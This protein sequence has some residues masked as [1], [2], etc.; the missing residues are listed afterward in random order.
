MFQNK[1]RIEG[2]L[3]RQ[4]FT[5]FMSAC[6][7][8]PVIRLRNT[9][10][11][12]GQTAFHA[13][14]LDVHVAA[15][16]PA[17]IDGARSSRTVGASCCTSAKI[18]A[19]GCLGVHSSSAA[20]LH[21]TRSNISFCFRVMRTWVENTNQLARMGCG[22]VLCAYLCPQGKLV[23]RLLGEKTPPSCTCQSLLLRRQLPARN[24][25]NLQRRAS[26]ERI[27]TSR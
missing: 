23:A 4:T 9:Q 6:V 22:E 16:A 3:A 7:N 26:L 2:V 27:P 11:T 21:S 8:L 1:S 18:L 13:W 19:A 25:Q 15:Q 20:Q 24:W 10:G 12:W 14:L 17:Q 5:L